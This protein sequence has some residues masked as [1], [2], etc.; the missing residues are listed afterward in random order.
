MPEM[1]IGQLARAS[2]FGEQALRYYDQLG[3]VRPVRRTA[4]GYRIYG[5][6]ALERLR[7]IRSAR[8]LGL[9]LN[10]I[11][12]I[13]DVAD[14]GRAPCSHVRALVERDLLRIDGEVRRLREVR[15]QLVDAKARLDDALAEGSSAAGEGCQCLLP[16]PE[17]RRPSS[18]GGEV[19]KRRG[20]SRGAAKA[21]APG[22]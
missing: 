2:G 21:A 16:A 4:S 6:T 15:R 3:L 8:D 5:A 1:R 18:R 13:L 19:P 22:R 12:S 10:D 20:S 11:R 7:F 17:R 14:G 9:S